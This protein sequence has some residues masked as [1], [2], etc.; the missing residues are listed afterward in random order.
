MSDISVLS[1]LIFSFKHILIM[2]I[3]Y[4]AG[5]NERNQNIEF[6]LASG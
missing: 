3:Q 1:R 4:Q 5:Y 2:Q 6:I